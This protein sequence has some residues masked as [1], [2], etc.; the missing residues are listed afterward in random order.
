[1]RSISLI[2]LA[3]ALTAP[4][5]IAASDPYADIS[6]MRVAF[7]HI[8]SV[9]AVERYSSGEFATVEYASPNRFHVTMRASQIALA[10]N[11][12]YDRQIG[13]VWKRSPNGAQHQA[14]LSAAWNI[15]GTP[16]VDVH[17]LFTIT[18][19]GSKRIDRTTLRGYLL[20]DA[21]GAYDAT[22]W[23]GPTYLPVFASIQMPDQTIKIHYINYNASVDVAMP[24]PGVGGTTVGDR[25][26]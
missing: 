5:A 23:M 2:L 11:V 12:E 9:I 22:I 21:A 26:P 1:M 3:L 16:S 15:A 6:T 17:K 25:S 24:Q 19:L 4:R 10:G 13:G 7:S 8:R 14:L 18:S 20:H